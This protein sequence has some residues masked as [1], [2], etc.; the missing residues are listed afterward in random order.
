MAEKPVADSLQTVEVKQ[1][2]PWNSAVKIKER[3]LEEQRMFHSDS[4]GGCLQR[5][6]MTGHSSTGTLGQPAGASPPR[7]TSGQQGL[8][9]TSYYHTGHKLLADSPSSCA[10]PA[11]GQPPSHCVHLAPQPLHRSLPQWVM[12][13]PSIKHLL[14]CHLPQ[15]DFVLFHQMVPA[16]PSL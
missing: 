14:E 2:F 7:N 1:R 9:D 15:E 8:P 5:R 13:S 6:S 12:S 4:E 3:Q 11:S 16:S 10:S